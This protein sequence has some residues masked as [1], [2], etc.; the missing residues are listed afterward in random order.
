LSCACEQEGSELLLQK[1][2]VVEWLRDERLTCPFDFESAYALKDGNGVVVGEKL[3]FTN[4]TDSFV[5]TLDY[6]FFVKEQFALT[7]ILH[8]PKSFPELNG[9]D[10]ENGHLLPSNIWPSDHLA[11]GA[12]LSFRTQGATTGSLDE[13]VP[14]FC[15]PAINEQSPASPPIPNAHGQRCGCGCVPQIKSLFEMAELRKQARLQLATES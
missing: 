5:N 14:T 4:V 3:P 2:D 12:C 8:V 1:L 7:E 10:I 6:I 13:T 15:W 9:D 11:V